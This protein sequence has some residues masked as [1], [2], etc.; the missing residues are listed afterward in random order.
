MSKKFFS[1]MVLL[2]LAL[3]AALVGCSDD[4]RSNG[5][6]DE[7]STETT[8]VKFNFTES[9]DLL[10]KTEV[11]STVSYYSFQGFNSAGTKIYPIV[12]ETYEVPVDFVEG[13][14]TVT[15]QDVPLDVTKFVVNFMA[16]DDTLVACSEITDIVLK[17][18][19]SAEANDFDVELI[20]EAGLEVNLASATI[21]TDAKSYQVVLLDTLFNQVGVSAVQSVSTTTAKFDEVPLNLFCGMIQWLDDS[22]KVIAATYLNNSLFPE[23]MKANE[24]YTVNASGEASQNLLALN[25][26][27]ADELEVENAVKC[28]IIAA[29][30][31]GEVRKEGAD[32]P[33]DSYTFLDLVPCSLKSV[34]VDYK[35][36]DGNV[37]AYSEVNVDKTYQPG[38]VAV[39]EIEEVKV[40]EYTHNITLKDCYVFAE[41]AA[42]S[43]VRLKVANGDTVLYDD[44]VDYSAIGEYSLTLTDS[45]KNVEVTSAIL[46]D[47]DAD[48]PFEWFDV[49]T[50][51]SGT[52]VPL[53]LSENEFANGA[54]VDD[55]TVC[56]VA[57]PRQ[58]DNVRK[59]LSGT[60]EQI[61]NIDFDG[62]CGL[63]V[64]ADTSSSG[65][66]YYN[67]EVVYAKARFLNYMGTDADHVQ[68]WV[69]IGSKAAIDPTYKGDFGGVYDGGSCTIDGVYV[70]HQ[71][72]TSTA[73]IR[74]RASLFGRAVG[75]AEFKNIYMGGNCYF[76]SYATNGSIL[77]NIEGDGASLENCHSKANVYGYNAI[78]G[79]VGW[80][81]EGDITLK[82]C[83][84]D[85][86]IFSQVDIYAPPSKLQCQSTGAGGLVGIVNCANFTA[87]N[88]TFDGY[89]NIPIMPGFMYT[90]MT[91]GMVG[92]VTNDKGRANKYSF[93]DCTVNG[94]VRGVLSV[95][96]FIG[97]ADYQV[98]LDNCQVSYNAE[99]DATGESS[100]APEG[101]GGLFGSFS[102]LP[103]LQNACNS[104]ATMTLRDDA[105]QVGGIL[106]AYTGSLDPSSV[107]A[108]LQAAV[109]S[110]GIGEPSYEGSNETLSR[111]KY[112]GSPWV[113]TLDSLMHRLP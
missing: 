69:P 104:L 1:L 62:S 7:P 108:F 96:G 84:F 26:N 88:C 29:Y 83:S 27:F 37:V 43:K 12:E 72:P 53:E 8:S 38:D 11:P 16:A 113:Q 58:L 77:G 39:V 89:V 30:D 33:L 31:G 91:G 59:H 95:G 2:A 40:P 81:E 75:G 28:D 45:K 112:C 110:G 18:A 46:K 61:A 80:A 17:P 99:V 50:A 63:R 74:N 109:M 105:T 68:G 34:H 82:N 102:V 87:E 22:N 106:G 67:M 10:G 6:G 100:N 92:E 93:K 23:E 66:E 76:I 103:T 41:D 71:T 48:I 20:S 86:T 56:K 79:L 90:R 97:Q 15:L 70:D 111:G 32:W 78:G 107:V 94:M 13:K 44:V 60:F 42:P 14:Q 24:K 35:D 57:N 3:T 4:K 65:E 5:G 85:G 19:S 73:Y 25:V 98:T 47:E 54:Y 36:A 101:V 55:E 52:D 49:D 9:G 64:V 51:V 21:P